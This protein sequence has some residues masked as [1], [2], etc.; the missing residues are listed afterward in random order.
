[1]IAQ[2]RSFKRDPKT[3]LNEKLENEVKRA[4]YSSNKFYKNLN[5]DCIKEKLNI[6]ENGEKKISKLDAEVLMAKTLTS[7]SG[8]EE[9]DYWKQII[10]NIYGDPIYTTSP[11]DSSCIKLNLRKLNSNLKLVKNFDSESMTDDDKEFCDE[12]TKFDDFETRMMIT[13]ILEL[14]K[15]W[16][17][18]DYVSI[19]TCG[20]MD[21][22]K[23]NEIILTLKLFSISNEK[24]ADESEIESVA[25]NIT[26]HID[27]VYSCR[28]SKLND[29]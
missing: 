4:T 17:G 8:F 25:Q 16:K 10:N 21:F 24:N 3:T 22:N 20:V 26:K 13:D 1:M 5:T 19:F 7:C 23:L 9:S 15:L 12:K 29:K 28:I 2:G 11:E 27:Q 6:P 18:I 14:P